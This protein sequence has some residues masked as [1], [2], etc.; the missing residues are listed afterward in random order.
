ME[1]TSDNFFNFNVLY[2]SISNN[3]FRFFIRFQCNFNDFTIVQWS[4]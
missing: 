2:I 1:K 4:D 3:L